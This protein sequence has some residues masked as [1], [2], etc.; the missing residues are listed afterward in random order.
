MLLGMIFW[1]NILHLDD[2]I[3][4]FHSL[5]IIWIQLQGATG[6]IIS[7]RQCSSGNVWIFFFCNSKIDE[8]KTKMCD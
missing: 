5:I 6:L 3:P 4:Q 1:F 8:R 7:F 2:F